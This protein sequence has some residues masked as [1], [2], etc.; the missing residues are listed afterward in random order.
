ME[1]A[2]LEIARMSEEIDGL[3]AEL[4]AETQRRIE[5][6]AHLLSIEDR[7]LEVEMEVREECFQEMEKKMR[8]EMERW[9]ARWAGEM[10]RADEHVDRAV[11]SVVDG[12]EKDASAGLVGPAGDG[13]DVVDGANR[14]GRTGDR[15]QLRRHPGLAHSSSS[16]SLARAHS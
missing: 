14:V 13:T 1:I 5:A 4:T 2:A 6:E 7:T 10:D 3:R 15:H 8:I 11:R 12:V 16:S 9:K